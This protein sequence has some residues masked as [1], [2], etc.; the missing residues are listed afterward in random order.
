MKNVEDGWKALLVFGENDFYSTWYGGYEIVAKIWSETDHSEKHKSI[1][2]KDNPICS[3]RIKDRITFA[4][5]NEGSHYIEDTKPE[6][7]RMIVKEWITN[8][9]KY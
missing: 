5:L 6:Y 1:K 9:A 7:L 3:L 2:I 4:K 8:N